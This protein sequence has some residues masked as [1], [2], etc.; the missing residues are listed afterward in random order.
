M[1]QPFLTIIFLTLLII[2]VGCSASQQTNDNSKEESNVYVFDDVSS[3]DSLKENIDK[4]GIKE[5]IVVFSTKNENGYLVQVGAFTSKSR[6][7][8][9][10][11]E[12]KSKTKFPL[13]VT[14]SDDVKLFVVQL[15]PF[16][17]KSEA[18]NVR[19]ELW[20]INIFKDAF[21]VPNH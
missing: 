1:R 17:T 5:E 7:E 13:S 10:C 15:P 19:D 12:A 6:A 8:T 4:T 3:V 21:I 9:F 2:S 14:Y 18:K 20:K 16:S 11:N